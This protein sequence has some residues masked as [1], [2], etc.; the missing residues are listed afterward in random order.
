M[1]TCR[2]CGRVTQATRPRGLCYRCF[3][4]VKIRRQYRA[5]ARWSGDEVDPTEAELDA[6]IAERMKPE[7]LTKWWAAEERKRAAQDHPPSLPFGRTL[8][9]PVH[10]TR[11]GVF[12]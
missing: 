9:R 10:D 4:D 2:H 12:E 6:L 3:D 1:F 11:R 5:Y 7:N 8:L